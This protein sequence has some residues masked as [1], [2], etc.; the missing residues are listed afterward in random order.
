MSLP[1]CRSYTSCG[2]I[3]YRSRQGAVR[4]R[5]GV[6]QAHACPRRGVRRAACMAHY[7]HCGQCLRHTRNIVIIYDSRNARCHS[8]SPAVQR[9]PPDT[10]PATFSCKR[11]KDG[12]S[13]SVVWPLRLIDTGCLEPGS[14]RFC[15]S[16]SV[17]SIKFLISKA[18]RSPATTNPFSFHIRV[19]L[20]AYQA[21]P[22]RRG[23][24]RSA[25]VLREGAAKTGRWFPH[26]AHAGTAYN[27]FV[28]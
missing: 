16:C 13:R 1:S 28:W 22:G 21:E 15:A 5:M 11:H 6:V 14:G 10:T 25:C 2:T 12:M 9:C 8:T 17:L 20:R 26:A 4:L 19:E 24:A 18:Y 27:F 23:R 3:R 7:D